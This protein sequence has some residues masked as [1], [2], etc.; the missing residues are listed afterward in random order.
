M[1]GINVNIFDNVVSIEIG[2]VATLFIQGSAFVSFWR[3][4]EGETGWRLIA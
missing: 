4:G 1:K 2:N 3:S